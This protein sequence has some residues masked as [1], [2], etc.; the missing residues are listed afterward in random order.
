M[1]TQ[2][3][4]KLEE[5]L[6]Q[7]AQRVGMGRRE[8]LRL[9][10]LSGSAAFL[11]ACGAGATQTTTPQTTTAATPVTKMFAKPE[12]PLLKIFA[13]ELG[14]RWDTSDAFITPV[15][16]FYVRNRY[17]SPI[18]D[19]K[20]WRLKVS[21]D[22]VEQPL[23]LT[24]DEL[25]KLPV[26]KAPRYMECFGN[27]RTINWEQL[28]HDVKGGNWGFSAISMGEWE[29]IPI[30]EILDRVKPKREAVQLL[31]WSGVDGTDTGRP[32]PMEEV[33]A[34]SDV[35]GLAFTLN[36]QPLTPD[37]GGPVRAIVPGWGGAASIKWLTEIRISTKR[38]WTRMHTKEEALIGPEYQAE[39]P[40]PSD[41]FL[42][43]TAND[44]R[45]VSATWQNVKSF[46]TLPLVLRKSVPP[47]RYPLKQGE[48]PR[49]SVG[50]QTMKG[51]ASSPYGI[52]KVEYSVDSGKTWSVAKL[53]PP[54]GEEYTWVRFE[55]PWDATPGIHTLMTRATDKKSNTQPDT[56]PFNELGIL[57]N[58]IP[59]FEVQV[60]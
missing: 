4:L 5:L 58:A 8:F 2:P 37:H 45:G 21:G 53:V 23:E 44:V 28:G 3:Q 59:K 31:F 22:A 46:L 54:G 43:V 9:L 35:I 25:I 11:G 32:M 12:E 30:G 7:R 40:S 57:C 39:Q 10:A 49:L 34:R 50:Q 24:F 33:L 18:L 1:H 41:D 51:Y 48:L 17:P 38:F 29:Y 55:F 16:Q 26:R 47:E 15:E 27:G 20:T 36:G 6:W 56:L 13:T 60:G 14:T 19:A 52:Q 42:G